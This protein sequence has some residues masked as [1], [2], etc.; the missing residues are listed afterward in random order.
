MRDLLCNSV[1]ELT[2][3]RQAEQ[4]QLSHIIICFKIMNL[5]F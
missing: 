1:G 3:C 2:D 4:L 5:I